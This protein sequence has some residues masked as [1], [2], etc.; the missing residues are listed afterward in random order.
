MGGGIE[1]ICS[2]EIVGRTPLSSSHKLYADDTQLYVSFSA[3]DFSHNI[4]HLEK[5]VSNV[6]NW[7]SKSK[8]TF[9]YTAILTIGPG[10]LYT[11]GNL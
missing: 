7:M 8:S 11:V 2:F 9:F 1:S 5:T 3:I 10:P 6:Y 4:A